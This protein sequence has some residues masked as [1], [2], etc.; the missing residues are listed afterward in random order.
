MTNNDLINMT[1]VNGY[2]SYQNIKFPL[3]HVYGT[4]ISDR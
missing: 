4:A 2:R 1:I 3:L